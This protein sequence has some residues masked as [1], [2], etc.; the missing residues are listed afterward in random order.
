MNY[1]NE[2]CLLIDLINFWQTYKQTETHTARRLTKYRNLRGGG[3]N[4]RC[5]YAV[6][7]EMGAKFEWGPKTPLHIMSLPDYLRDVL[8]E[9]FFKLGASAAAAE[10]CWVGPGWI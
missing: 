9:D 7:S 1:G 10:F 4:W 3:L 5:T 6:C 2:F 8:W